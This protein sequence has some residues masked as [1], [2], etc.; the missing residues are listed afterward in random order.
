MSRHI[1]GPRFERALVYA[2]QIHA[3]QRRKGT[4][5]PYIA[6]LLGVTSIVL[7]H[8]ADEDEAIAALLHDTVEDH[9]DKTSFAEIRRRFGPRVAEIVRGCT[10]AFTTPKPPWIDC[11]RAYLRHLRCANS[12]VRLVSAADKLHNVREILDDL[13]VGGEDVWSSFTATKPQA[14]WY[15]R[16]VEKIL[17]RHGPRPLVAELARTVTQLERESSSSPH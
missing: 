15:Y 13:R 3:G 9:P 2:A 4:A 6:H 12:S 10:D 7:T 5:R 17:R 1:L 16:Q 8:G 11:K 14:L